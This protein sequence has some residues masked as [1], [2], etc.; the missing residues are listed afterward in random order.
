MTN[1]IVDSL[2]LVDMTVADWWFVHRINEDYQCFGISPLGT[3]SYLCAD[4]NVC[5][6]SWPDG[7]TKNFRG[8]G[9][10][11]SRHKLFVLF[12]LI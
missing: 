9:E 5:K 11:N 6:P 8:R 3:W 12:L 1:T 7:T 2:K 10:Y 4:S